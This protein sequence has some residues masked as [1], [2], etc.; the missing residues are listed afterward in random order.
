MDQV[1]NGLFPP[2][3]S[4]APSGTAAVKLNRTCQVGCPI[5][6]PLPCPS[7]Q[8]GRLANFGIRIAGLQDQEDQMRLRQL[9]RTVPAM[10]QA[11]TFVCL[12]APR[13]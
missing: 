9:H 5:S 3:L 11:L 7:L 2:S 1:A 13:H 4:T 10:L 8:P 6:P 12:R